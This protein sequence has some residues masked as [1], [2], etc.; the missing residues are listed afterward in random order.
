MQNFMTFFGRPQNG[1][2]WKTEQV[3][4]LHIIKTNINWNDFEA[5]KIKGK[6]YEDHKT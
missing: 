2:F 5:L 1:Q 6:H 4:L 3:A